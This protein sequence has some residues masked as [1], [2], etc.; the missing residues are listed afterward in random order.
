VRFHYYEDT[1]SLYIDLADRPAADSVEVSPGVVLDFDADGAV[2]G[3][4]ID[5]ASKR[6]N[7]SRVDI[8]SLPIRSVVVT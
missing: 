1:D 6:V 7:M 2:V 8:E 4:D 5:Q 3:L